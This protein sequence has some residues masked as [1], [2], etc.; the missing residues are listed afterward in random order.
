M[1]APFGG[2][3][4]LPFDTADD[5]PRTEA[6]ASPNLYDELAALARP[7][8]H[9]QRY[10][11]TR[12]AN[13]NMQYPPQGIHAFLRGY[14]HYKRRRLVWQQAVQTQGA[15]GRRDGSDA[16]LLH[17]GPRQRHGGN[18]GVGDAVGR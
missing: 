12:E 6:E 13:D 17:H 7:R 9:Y 1:S 18:R 4:A 2:T 5:P 8:K 3:P 15:H 11:T 10:Y 14:Y 16:D